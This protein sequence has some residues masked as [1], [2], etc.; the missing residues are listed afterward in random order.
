MRQSCPSGRRKKFQAAVSEPPSA[1][2]L[3]TLHRLRPSQAVYEGIE[4]TL[5]EQGLS[6]TSTDCIVNGVRDLDPDTAEEAGDIGDELADVLIDLAVTC[7]FP[8]P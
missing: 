1:R 4:T 2:R 5:P 8:T 3:I 6:P 7:L